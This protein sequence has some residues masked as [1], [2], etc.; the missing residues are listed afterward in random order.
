MNTENTETDQSTLIEYLRQQIKQLEEALQ[1]ARLKEKV[2]YDML[3]ALQAKYNTPQSSSYPQTQNLIQ[4]SNPQE[5]LEQP[6]IDKLSWLGKIIFI[7]RQAGKPLRAAELYDKL[8]QLEFSFSYKTK[9][10]M[11]LSVILSKSVKEKRLSLHKLHGTKG[12]YYA[13]PEWVN[14]DGSLDSYMMEQMY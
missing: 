14:S 6:D 11:L 10:M 8:D 2:A 4:Q 5:N 1:A 12:G 13:L 7:L 9:P 3:E